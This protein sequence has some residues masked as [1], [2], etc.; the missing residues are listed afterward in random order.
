[1]K[2]EYPVANTYIHFPTPRSASLEEYWQPRSAFSCPAS[3][4]VSLEEDPLESVEYGPVSDN[5]VQ[6][7]ATR[8][9]SLEDEEERRKVASQV[10]IWMQSAFNELQVPEALPALQAPPPRW[11]SIEDGEDLPEFIGNLTLA[12]GED[13]ATSTQGFQWPATR[14]PSLDEFPGTAMLSSLNSRA[15]LSVAPAQGSE[16]PNILLNELMTANAVSNV[17]SFAMPLVAPA[18]AP[19]TSV[20][21]FLQAKSSLIHNQS[22]A[23][24]ASTAVSTDEDQALPTP[25]SG[26]SD[27]E[28]DVE[29]DNSAT[30]KISLTDQ[31]GLWSI[32]SSAHEMGTCKPCAFLWKDPQQPGCQNGS[33]C[34]FCHLCPPGEVKRRKK[35]KM[36][37][38]KVAKNLQYCE[39]FNM[40]QQPQFESQC[41]Q[42]QSAAEFG[43]W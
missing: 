18:F 42:S 33:D 1:M 6:W 17:E 23:S 3:R 38:R 25:P 27:D 36:F 7:P 20:D 41:W 19:C 13:E 14:G 39:Q 11:A 24:D 16:V 43:M 2:V 10:N 32:G 37:M 26:F 15:T 5:M 31:L 9:P 40:E 21:E 8:G 34:V 29:R 30:L 22:F 28:A 35:Q 12:K 4:M